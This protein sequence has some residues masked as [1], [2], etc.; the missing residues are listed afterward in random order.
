MVIDEDDISGGMTQK[1]TM[2]KV[3]VYSR[4][5]THGSGIRRHTVS[6]DMN[7]NVVGIICI[8]LFTAYVLHV[9]YSYIECD[10]TV[11]SLN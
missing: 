2:D 4:T 10:Y 11:E 1:D 3:G 7:T 6:S 9:M 8:Y 5:S